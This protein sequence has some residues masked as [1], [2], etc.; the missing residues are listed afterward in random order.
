M[1]NFSIFITAAFLAFAV[2]LG[3]NVFTMKKRVVIYSK[4]ITSSKVVFA[5]A[6]VF[7]IFTF[8]YA[9]NIWDIVRGIIMVVCILMFI[10][11]TDG[12]AEDCFVVSGKTIL[13]KN[14]TEYCTKETKKGI[15]VYFNYRNTKN[16]KIFSGLINFDG[17]K[18]DEINKFLKER[19]GKK[20]RRMKIEA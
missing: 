13:F 9:Q 18:A 7:G 19:L 4:F 12:I 20:F 14:V 17:K 10:L 5:I 1:D 8:F 16:T 15:V 2:Y 3:S 6:L 11:I